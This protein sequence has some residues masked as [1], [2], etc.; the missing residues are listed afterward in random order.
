LWGLQE[1]QRADERTRTTFLLNT[2][3][4]SV[5]AERCRGLQIPHKQGDPLFLGLL[6]IAVY[7]VRVR[8]KLGS[9][10]VSTPWIALCRTIASQVPGFTQK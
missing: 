10:G 9:S 4:R 6:T 3:V 5:V 1:K 7:C 2:S 8:A